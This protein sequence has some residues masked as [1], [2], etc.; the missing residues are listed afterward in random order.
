MDGLAA[1]RWGAGESPSPAYGSDYVGW[2]EAQ[3]VLPRALRVALTL[4]ITRMLTWDN[5]LERRTQ[6]WVMTIQGQRLAV[7]GALDG[8]HSLYPILAAAPSPSTAST[9]DAIL[10]LA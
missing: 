1:E 7:A 10:R 8:S 5:Q 3:R 6:T 4:M 9:S 2:I